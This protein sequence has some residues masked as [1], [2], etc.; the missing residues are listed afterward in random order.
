MTK[1]ITIL[2]QGGSGGFALFYY[3]LLSGKYQTG[4][5]DVDVNTLV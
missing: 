1:D 4:L 3:L 5:P 2:Y